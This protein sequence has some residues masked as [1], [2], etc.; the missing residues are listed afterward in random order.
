MTTYEQLIE[1]GR[2]EGKFEGK[3]EVILNGH[4]NGL[5]VATLSNITQLPKEEVVQILREHGKK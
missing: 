2:E 3:I 1:Q 4:N 5:D